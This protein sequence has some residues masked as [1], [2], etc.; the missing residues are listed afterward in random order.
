[1]LLLWAPP[2]WVLII[3]VA[4][5]GASCTILRN[6]NYT[7]YAAVM[8]PFL[9]LLLGS[10]HKI[11]STIIVERLAATCLGCALVLVFGYLVWRGLAAHP[12]E[13]TTV[14]TRPPRRGE[15]DAGKNG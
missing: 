10:G 9:M 7:A 14:S 2:V 13:S 12:T 3:F 6:A 15:K 11:N 4:L 5:L 1:M 8:T